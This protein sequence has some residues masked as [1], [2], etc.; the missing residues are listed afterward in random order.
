MD[1]ENEPTRSLTPEELEQALQDILSHALG[2]SMVVTGWSMVIEAADSTMKRF[3]FPISRDEQPIWTTKALLSEALDMARNDD[4]ADRV[5]E[6][7][8]ESKSGE[9][10][11][12]D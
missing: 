5:V 9:D 12:E 11:E 4:A 6:L 8:L 2:E 10:E 3:L 7:L 1:E